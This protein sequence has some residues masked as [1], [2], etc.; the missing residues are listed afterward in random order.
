[1]PSQ[2]KRARAGVDLYIA[3][4]S[5]QSLLVLKLHDAA[6]RS[7]PGAASCLQQVAT[8]PAVDEYFR[9]RTS[10]VRDSAV[11]TRTHNDTHTNHTHTLRWASSVH[12]SLPSLTSPLCCVATPIPVRPPIPSM[13][14]AGIDRVQAAVQRRVRP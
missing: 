3:V 9:R 10:E 4:A 6:A 13:T 1:M 5:Q 14:M 8:L 11:S 2:A 7:G 12:A